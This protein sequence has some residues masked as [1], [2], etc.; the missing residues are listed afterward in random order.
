MTIVA[1]QIAQRGVHLD[2]CAGEI[3]P[4]QQEITQIAVVLLEVQILR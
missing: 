2:R 1:C 4:R 3:A